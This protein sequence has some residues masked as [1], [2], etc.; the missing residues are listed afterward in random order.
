MLKQFEGAR[1][2][3]FIFIGTVFLV[4]AILLLGNKESLFVST[5]KVKAYF[6]RVEGLKNGAPVRL[7]GYDIGSVSTVNLA[8]DTTGRVEVV[9]RIDK[10]YVQFI[11]IDSKAAIETEGLVG[12]MLVTITPGSPSKEVITEGGVIQSQTPINLSEI[13]QETNAIL[14]NVK[15]LTKDFSDVVAKINSGEGSVG[16]LVNDDKLYNSVN[17]VVR[18]ADKSLNVITDKMNEV[19]TMFTGLYGNM[20]NIASNV[21]GASAEVKNIISDIK[22]GKGMIGALLNDNKSYDSVKTII[23]NFASASTNVVKI[24]EKFSENMEALKHNWLFKSYFEQRGYWDKSDFEKELDKKLKDI[25][26]QREDLDKKITE[27]KNLEKETGTK[28]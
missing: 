13:V 7:S 4:L 5:I 23:N 9:M 25:K 22:T 15:N 19:S 14:A 2:G 1:L 16:K 11:H 10:S 8:Q 17:Q 28:K 27:L 24:S 12:K 26:E 18:S 6:T 21:E 3:I 20:Q